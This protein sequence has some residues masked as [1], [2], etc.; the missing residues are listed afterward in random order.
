MACKNGGFRFKLFF[1]LILGLIIF[2]FYHCSLCIKHPNLFGKSEKLDVLWD[3]GLYDSNILIT[4]RK[5]R[6]EW[7]AQQSFVVQVCYT[8]KFILS[9]FTYLLLS[10]CQRGKN[11]LGLNILHFEIVWFMKGLWNSFDWSSN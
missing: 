9:C 11:S 6:P 1:L 5:P 10:F 4:Y 3:K 2:C 7:L 8:E